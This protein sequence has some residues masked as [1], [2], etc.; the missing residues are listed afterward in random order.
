MRKIKTWSPIGI[1]ICCIFFG[2]CKTP[3]EAL[4]SNNQVIPQSYADL[5]DTTNSAQLKWRDFF[6]DQN[7]ISLIDTAINKNLDLMMTFQEIEV[8]KNNVHSRADRGS[9]LLPVWDL[10]E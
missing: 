9:Q 2:S 7:L 4:T 1:F 3:S 8:A 5:R 6:K 10:P